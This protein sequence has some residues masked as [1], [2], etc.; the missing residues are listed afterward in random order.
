MPTAR[1]PLDRARVLTT[2]VR[3]ADAEGL[4]AVTMRRLADELAVTPM[5]LYKH[6]ADKEDLLTGMVDAV[7]DDMAVP[8]VAHPDDWRD[9][10]RAALHRSRLVLGRH[11]WA[12]LA[13][14]SRT[15]RTAAVLDHMERLSAVFIN[16]GFSADLTHHVMHLLGNRIWGF[17]PELFTDHLGRAASG[18]GP[19]R[20]RG[21]TPDPADYP[22]ILAIAADAQQRRPRATGCDEDFE[23][24]FALDVLL[25]GIARLQQAGWESPAADAGDLTA[26]GPDRRHP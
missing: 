13:I 21:R 6:V 20:G 22:S 11:P 12:R 9:N 25:D 14:E 23:M 7:V 19:S 26:T 2:A 17:S 16:A 18:P 3:L 24:D 4:G 10:I 8:G 1:A 5:A 15:E